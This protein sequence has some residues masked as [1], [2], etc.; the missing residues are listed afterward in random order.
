MSRAWVVVDLGFGDAGKGTIT[1]FLVRETGARLVVRFNGGAQAGHNVV[2][3]DGRTHTFAQFGAGTFVPD[4]WTY[5]AEDVVVHPSALLVEARHLEE[6]SFVQQP[7]LRL[8]IAENTRIITPFHQAA[9]RARELA[10]GNAQHGTCGVGVGETVRDAFEHRD[11]VILAR[12]LRGRT[13]LFR[14]LERARERLW[15]SLRDEIAVLGE[16]H[17]ELAVFSDPDL[18]VRWMEFVRPI[19]ACVV[20]ADWLTCWLRDKP[21][22]VVCE[23][24]QGV[25]L[26]ETYGFHPH[27]TW[28][29]CTFR[30]ADSILRHHGFSGDELHIGVMRTYMTRHGAGPFPTED[31][32]L[33]EKLPEIHNASAGW[34][35]VFRRGH[36]DLVLARYAVRACGGLD[37]LAITHFDRIRA[38]DR[39]AIAYESTG[40]STLFDHDEQGRIVNLRS[41]DLEHQERL[42][43][44]LRQV[45]PVWAAAP[46]DENEWIEELATALAVPVWITSAGTTAAHKTWHVSKP[47]S[48]AIGAQSTS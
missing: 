2:T 34:Q 8:A 45:R 7:L 9:N 15:A 32:E 3:E 28:S 35:G 48:S 18:I 4:T 33:H 29:D 12:D 6:R 22:D 44:T 14:Q 21:G 40:E 30:G 39:W 47:L 20:D 16:D 46:G 5:L 42:G 19:C 24:A 11:D 27:T 26:D 23:G 38:L 10:R 37:A 25:L 13:R 41:G 1:D 43:Q 31:S 17:S 36:L